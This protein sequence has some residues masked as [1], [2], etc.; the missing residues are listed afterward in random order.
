MVSDEARVEVADRI[1]AHYVEQAEVNPDRYRIRNELDGLKVD[2][3]RE[4]EAVGFLAVR[5][6]GTSPEMV[7]AVN[8]IVSEK[9]FDE[10]KQDFLSQL[11]NYKEYVLLDKLEPNKY[12]EDLARFTSLQ[13][14]PRGAEEADVTPDG[15]IPGEERLTPGVYAATP[16]ENLQEID[17]IPLYKGKGVVPNIIERGKHTEEVV[18]Y[19]RPKAEGEIEGEIVVQDRMELITSEPVEVPELLTAEEARSVRVTVEGR[20]PV[21]IDN[22]EF[23][24]DEMREITLKEPTL[25]RAKKTVVNE[26]AQVLVDRELSE[27]EREGYES[28]AQIRKAL[29]T[30]TGMKARIH[31]PKEMFYESVDDDDVGTVKWTEEILQKIVGEDNTVELLP[32]TASVGLADLERR[33]IDPQETEVVDVLIAADVH[34][35]EIEPGKIEQ[36]VERARVLAIPA[37]A[38]EFKNGWDANLETTGWGTVVA[39]INPENIAKT[40]DETSPASIFYDFLTRVLKK[41]ERNERGEVIRL[42]RERLYG[43][44]PYNKIEGY[45]DSITDKALLADLKGGVISRMAMLINNMLFNMKMEPFKPGEAFR[46]KLAV[47]W[48][49]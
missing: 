22:K 16:R 32:Y 13:E 49:A 9:D 30:V 42:K 21:E 39:A 19:R 12:K 2:F 45:L 35:A 24:P 23:K 11:V 40:A 48:S 44:L 47:L 4:G 18:L 10:I 38:L 5:P 15:V 28:L 37:K 20:S 43:F 3:L 27:R 33:Q 36:F 1:K 26:R 46:S 29:R 25:K 6:S 17:R 7:V 31:V 8:S 41:T 14:T 34:L